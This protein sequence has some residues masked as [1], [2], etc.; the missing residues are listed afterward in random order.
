MPPVAGV[1]PENSPAKITD[2]LLTADD[3]SPLHCT[4]HAVALTADEAAAE[5]YMC[6]KDIV[7]P[8]QDIGDTLGIGFTTI[9]SQLTPAI[10]SRRFAQSLGK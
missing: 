9:L 4:A 7:V 2:I 6:D 1:V 3:G 5:W 8:L 10:L